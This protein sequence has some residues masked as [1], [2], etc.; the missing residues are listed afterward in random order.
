MMDYATEINF[1][2]GV[3]NVLLPAFRCK[4]AGIGLV[5]FTIRLGSGSKSKTWHSKSLTWRT[6]RKASFT[7]LSMKIDFRGITLT[8]PLMRS[9]YSITNLSSILAT[10]VRGLVLS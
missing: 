5:N 10:T 2:F 8:A 7:N 6:Q 3:R 9:T 1:Q 4:R